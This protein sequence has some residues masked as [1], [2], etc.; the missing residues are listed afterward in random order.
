MAVEFGTELNK[1]FEIMGLLYCGGHPDFVE[2]EL[3]METVTE[4]GLDANEFNRTIAVVLKKYISAFQKEMIKTNTEDFDFFFMDSDFEF[5]LS[6]Q[7]VCANHPE[8]FARDLDPL[9]EH[10]ILPAFAR[11]LSE[12][13]GSFTNT[14]GFDEMIAILNNTGYSPGTCWKFMQI[15][16]SPNKY[17][18]KLSHIIHSNLAAYEKALT[19][20][21]RTLDK[22]LEKFPQGTFISAPLHKN[23]HLTPVLIYAPVE[24][25]YETE[26]SSNVFISLFTDDIYK[27]Q[28]K[29]KEAQKNI[30]PMLKAM[31][32]NSKFDILLSLTKAP[33]Y[34]LE[35]A[36]E[37]HLSAATVSHHMNVLLACYLVSV[38]KRDG[39]VYYTLIKETMEDLL[40]DLQ[41]KFLGSY[42]NSKV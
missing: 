30:L 8:W 2:K 35:L 3:L 1:Y 39:K 11:I 25:I 9:A 36:E 27:M 13:T 10:E 20:I 31:S 16:Q 21:Q 38:E 12:E 41:H 7:F 34:N 28:Q 23:S 42:E 26:A 17:L 22:L 6:L 33:K 24:L 29:S 15:F 5:M 19:A 18:K 32:D 37:L 40:L 4:L 14:P